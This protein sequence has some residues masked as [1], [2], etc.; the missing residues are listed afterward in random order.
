M[1]GN[2]LIKTKQNKTLLWLKEMLSAIFLIM[3]IY[4]INFLV[5]INVRLSFF[6]PIIHVPNRSEC[7]WRKEQTAAITAQYG[8]Q[9][10]YKKAPLTNLSV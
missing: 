2:D 3:V 7:R 6:C 5:L 9:R 8:S 10:H 1:T 4:H